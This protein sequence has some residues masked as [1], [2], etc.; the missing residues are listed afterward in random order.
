MKQLLSPP[1][2]QLIERKSQRFKQNN[3]NLYRFFIGFLILMGPIVGATMLFAAPLL[4]YLAVNANSVGEFAIVFGSQFALSFVLVQYY[5]LFWQRSELLYLKLTMGK[6]TAFLHH[7]LALLR[8]AILLHIVVFAAFARV[9][10]NVASAL[11]ILSCY[12]IF[13]VM[14]LWRY[15]V[16]LGHE[17]TL[18]QRLIRFITNNNVATT[19]DPSLIR[20]KWKLYLH[21]LRSGGWLR[22]LLVI[23]VA[24]LLAKLGSSS[25]DTMYLLGIGSVLF[26]VGLFFIYLFRKLV[27]TN[28]E[29]NHLFWLSLSEEFDEELRRHIGLFTT[30]LC[31]FHV[32]AFLLP[33]FVL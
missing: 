20:L 23:A 29:V 31:I 8:Q 15:R 26:A 27:L 3:L 24:F 25:I 6:G 2:F 10:L 16:Y 9:D 22:L 18:Q 13:L 21:L 17:F 7:F 30:F 4:G 14:F 5:F 11:Y 32:M 33:Y 28:Y 1:L 19:S 12:S